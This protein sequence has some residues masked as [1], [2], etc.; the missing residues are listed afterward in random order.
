MN[1]RIRQKQLA[2]LISA[3]FKEIIRQPAVIFWGIIFPILMA[4]G[5]GIAFTSQTDIVRHVAVIESNHGLSENTENKLLIQS[6][7][8]NHADKIESAENKPTQ[9]KI[10][11]SDKKL[12]NTTFVF[13]KTNWRQAEVLLKRGNLGIIMDEKNGRIEYHFDP[14]NTDAHFSYLKLSNIFNQNN[15][16]DGKNIESIQPL[17][18]RGTRYIDFLVPGL[19]A[20]GIMMSCMWGMSYG[21]IDKRSKK[22]LRRMVATPMK[23][24]YFLISLMTV[25]MAM[26]LIESSLL[27]L[28]AWLVF[29]ITIQ[30]S[31][32]GLFAIFL[33]GNIAFGGIAI[34]VSCRTSNT[35]IGNGL[36]NAVVMPMMVLSGVFFSYH[37]FPD[38]CIPFIQKLPMTIL[39]DGLRSIFIEGAGF[40][41]AMWPAAALLSIGVFFFSVGLRF[42]KWH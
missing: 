31:I 37:N 35:E 36:V 14:L 12:G 38:W 41:E 20:M 19:M 4:L 28:F 26:N 21:M 9:Y 11:L 30:G 1:N 25:R 29:N 17:T 33:A 16:P 3:H 34:F 15:N 27:F 7:L 22:L 24:S 13:E 18:V 5:L 39:A 32:T 23:R 8:E 2:Q 42:F 6:F 10:T 40:T